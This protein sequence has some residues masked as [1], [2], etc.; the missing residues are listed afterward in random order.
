M[1]VIPSSDEY[2][3]KAITDQEV[4]WY[5]CIMTM[6]LN[7][8]LTFVYIIAFQAMG[9]YT[10]WNAALLSQQS[11]SAKQ[12]ISV[13]QPMPYQSLNVDVL[14]HTSAIPNVSDITLKSSFTEHENIQTSSSARTDTIQTSSLTET[15]DKQTLAA[16]LL[17]RIYRGDKAGLTLGHVLQWMQFMRYAGVDHFYIY[18]AYEKKEEMLEAFFRYYPYVTYIDWS[19]H[20][21]YEMFK[22]QVSAYQHSIDTYG[23]SYTWHTAMDI[24]EYPTSETDMEPYFMRRFLHTITD[25]TISEISMH[26]HLLLGG[27]NQDETLWLAE[28]YTRVTTGHSTLSKPI[29]RPNRVSAAIHHNQLHSGRSIDAEKTQLR[30]SHIWGARID[31]WAV[32]M[33]QHVMDITEDDI[34][35][36]VLIEKVRLFKTE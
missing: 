21:P 23:G 3:I 36:P 1:V 35:M 12:Y 20:T 15:H 13:G 31:E 10:V 4:Y 22:T 6:H 30:M 9:M 14:V 24:D 2:G 25:D 5:K 34:W 29:Y 7:T 18:D 26:N 32:K 33:S 16:I 27:A 17:V 19:A 8:I 11:T 28:R